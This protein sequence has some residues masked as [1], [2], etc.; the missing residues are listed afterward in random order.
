MT[1]I[2]NKELYQTNQ[3]Q[4]I[5]FTAITKMVSP[6]QDLIV[7]LNDAMNYPMSENISAK[8]YQLYELTALK[9]NTTNNM[10]FFHL[11]ISSLCFHIEELTT[12]L[13]KHDYH[14]TLLK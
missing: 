2:S 14:L 4:K 9:K 13:S 5:K 12:L 7:Q 6:S 10:S 3:G 1:N 8:Y 11:N